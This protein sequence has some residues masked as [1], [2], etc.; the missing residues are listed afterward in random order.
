MAASC[1][2]NVGPSGLTSRWRVISKTLS[3]IDNT[4]I[5]RRRVPVIDIDTESL[6]R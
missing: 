4:E 1:P 2:T 6:M 3:A 5:L